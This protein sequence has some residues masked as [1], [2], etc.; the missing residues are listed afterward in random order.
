MKYT[1]VP[2]LLLLV[3]TKIPGDHLW[4]KQKRQKDGREEGRLGNLESKEWCDG[5]FRFSFCSFIQ[6][7][8]HREPITGKWQG[9]QHRP[10]PCWGHV[11][12]GR[13][14]RLLSPP[15]S[16]VHCIWKSKQP[17]NANNHSEKN[18]QQKQFGLIPGLGI[19]PGEGN[20]NPLQYSCLGNP[21]DRGAWWDTV[22]AVAKSGTRL[23]N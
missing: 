12:E 1:Y 15:G 11:K 17:R 2:L 7:S 21:M 8:E 5:E 3:T 14:V 18:F 10:A 19:S 16:T 4:N 23:S 13:E 6:Y 22:H 9:T 20:G